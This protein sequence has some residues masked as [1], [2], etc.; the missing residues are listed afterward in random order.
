MFGS[1]NEALVRTTKLWV[2]LIS[3]KYS[4]WFDPS[5]LFSLKASEA[6]QYH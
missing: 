1:D 3:S 2:E 5:K 6:R 4:Y